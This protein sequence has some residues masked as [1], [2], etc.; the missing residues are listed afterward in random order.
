MNFLFALD[1][2][3][4]LRIF[5]ALFRPDM[6]CKRL[7]IASIKCFSAIIAIPSRTPQSRTIIY[8]NALL[9]TPIQAEK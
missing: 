4:S 1:S 5:S 2:L 9:R 6:L 8:R 3:A 7:D